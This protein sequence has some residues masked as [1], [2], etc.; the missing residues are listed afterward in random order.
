[1]CEEAQHRRGMATAEAAKELEAEAASGRLD[2][3]VVRATIAAAG[4]K[5]A[6]PR[7]AW[8]GGLT[9][10]EVGVLREVARGQSNKES[11]RNL[12][13]SEATV[14][15][16]VLNIYTKIGVNS[17]ADAALFAMEN[18]LVHAKLATTDGSAGRC[19]EAW[20]GTAAFAES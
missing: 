10:R 5:V 11:G 14:Q 13:I 2:R 15:S 6:G 12:F 7:A 4:Q 19:E 18:E 3:E 20:T 1:M 17:R 9:E 8:P 16:H